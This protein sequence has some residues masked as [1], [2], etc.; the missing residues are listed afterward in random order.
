[1][2]EHLGG[3]IQHEVGGDFTVPLPKFSGRNE[4][5]SMWTA[6]FEAY[7]ELVVWSGILDVAAA[8]AGDISMTGTQPEAVRSGTVIPAV[9]L[10]KTEGKAFSI[11]QHFTRS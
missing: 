8:Q 6:R 10:T 1:M 4:D 9:L 5:W 2:G 11:A 3:R 7:A